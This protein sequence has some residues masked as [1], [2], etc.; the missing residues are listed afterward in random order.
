MRVMYDKY[1]RIPFIGIG[2]V[3]NLCMPMPD[4]IRPLIDDPM[5]LLL[6]ELTDAGS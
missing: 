2:M 6:A 1:D 5:T 4:S 3:V